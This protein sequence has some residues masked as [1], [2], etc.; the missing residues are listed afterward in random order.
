ML[1][2][3]ATDQNV[4]NLKAQIYDTNSIQANHVYFYSNANLDCDPCSIMR[5]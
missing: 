2:F 4:K 1:T 3:V 5:V